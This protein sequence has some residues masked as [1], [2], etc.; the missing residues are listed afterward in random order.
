[1]ASCNE[2]FIPHKVQTDICWSLS[3]KEVGVHCF[4]HI[5]SKLFPGICLSKDALSKSFSRE[6]SVSLLH[7]FED[8]FTHI[9]KCRGECHVNPRCWSCTRSSERQSEF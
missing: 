4:L 3:V 7:Y 5:G 9:S 2:N 8:K 1:M 6:T